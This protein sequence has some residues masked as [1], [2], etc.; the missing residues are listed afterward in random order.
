MGSVSSLISG[1]SFHSKHCRAS[2]YKLRKP[3]HLK[4]LNRYS[5]GLLRFGF[6]QDSGH[7]SAS[8]SSK[9]E[10]FFYIKVSQKAPGSQRPELGEL[11]VPAGTSGL[12][13]GTATPQK[14]MPF[15]AQLEVVSEENRPWECGD[16]PRECGDVP[17]E[18]CWAQSS[19]RCHHGVA[20]APEDAQGEQGQPGPLC[21]VPTSAFGSLDQ[22][23]E[24]VWLLSFPNPAVSASRAL[25]G[26]CSCSSVGLWEGPG[27]QKGWE[28]T[29][30]VG[31][32]AEGFGSVLKI[33]VGAEELGSVLRIWGW[34]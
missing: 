23:K 33:W 21:P 2:Q 34:C 7:K 11:A 14:L 3:S 16:V 5:D 13:F 4:K 30:G 19:C 6:S 26:C 1:H 27:G 24:R 29:Q 10:D 20:L 15:P 12:D 18:R 25:G 32:G 28:G 17:R 31:V 22:R 9:N 8:K